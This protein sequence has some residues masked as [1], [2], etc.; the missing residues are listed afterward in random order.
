MTPLKR[1]RA[2]TN[3]TGITK[4]NSSH[5]EEIKSDIKSPLAFTTPNQKMDL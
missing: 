2:D 1:S 3:V 5:D 4:A